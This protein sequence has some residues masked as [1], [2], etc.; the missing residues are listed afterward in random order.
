[1]KTFRQKIQTK[2]RAYFHLLKY[3]VSPLF[4]NLTALFSHQLS[5]SVTFM[6]PLSYPAT[7][8]YLA[9]C[10]MRCSVPFWR[11]NSKVSD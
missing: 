6:G 10:D 4:C 3:T 8:S 2:T 9:L 11:I 1:M 7:I 5:A